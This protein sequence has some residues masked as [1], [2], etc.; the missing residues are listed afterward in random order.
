MEP[1]RIMP[2][3]EVRPGMQGYGLTVFE[4]TK[5]ER[6]K[7]KVISVLRNFLPKQAVILMRVEDAR[8]EHTGVAAGMSGSPIYIDGKVV[9]ALA[10]GWAFS[11]EPLAGITPIEAMLEDSRAPLRVEPGPTVI[12]R[13]LRPV[14]LGDIRLVP[15]AVPLAFAGVASS[16]LDDVREEFAALGLL[17]ISAG[18]GGRGDLAPRIEP[19]GAVGVEL[20]RGDMSVT[21]TGTVT[22]VDGNT[23]LAFGHPM[24][25]AGQVNLPM[26]GAEIH[27]IMPSLANAFKLA[28]PLAEVGALLH[29]RG[30]AIVG[31]LG[32]KAPRMP[33]DVNVKRQGHKT[34]TFKVQL[35]QSDT[36]TPLLVSI[37]TA[38][39]VT[40]AE[41]DHADMMIDLTTTLTVANRPPIVLREQLFSTAGLNPRVFGAGQGWKALRQVLDNPFGR[42]DLRQLRVDATVAYKRE[43]SEIVGVQVP[44]KRVRS[45]QMLSVRVQLRPFGGPDIWRTLEVKLPPHIDGQLVDVEVASG[46]LVA[47]FVPKPENLKDLMHSFTNYYTAGQI[48]VS[49]SLPE[50]GAALGGAPLGA[51][52]PSAID[53]LL[54]AN[55]TRN[56]Q[57]HQLYGRTVLPSDM[58]V[59]GKAQVK[60]RIDANGLGGN[61]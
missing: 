30:A 57:M 54:P 20:V 39:A 15:V 42:V 14:A 3:S 25:R 41:P 47:P 33:L 37:V 31:V 12:A 27:A 61:G 29:D 7:V 38:S 6:F 8:I 49:V 21:A 40:A 1:A 59:T 36:L 23:V 11:K 28:S 46:A 34:Q 22:Y 18:G 24:M 32:A 53:T 35:A 5:P 13:A 55:Q 43:A 50:T 10:Y 60:V 26:V 17:P 19:G 44:S 48:V 58:V 51:L 9:G 56:A 16:T 52:P 2:L 4:G 45:G